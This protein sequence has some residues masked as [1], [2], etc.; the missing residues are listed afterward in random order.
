[1]TEKE[2]IGKI[3]KLRQIR[4]RKDWVSLTKSQILGEEPRF[5]FFPYFKPS[6]VL[7]KIWVGKPA[8]AIFTVVFIFLGT[9][10]YGL[11]KNS[12]PGD[13]L[14]GIR[15]VVHESQ[16]VFISE[17]EKPAFQLKLANE[18]LEDLT[19]ASAKNL[20]PTINEFQ[21]NISAAAKTL[22]KI[23]ATTTDPVM[24]KKIVEETKK[25]EENKQKV[26]SL[27]VVIEGEET[28]EF[29]KALAKIVENL[30]EDLKTRT[31][32]EEKAKTLEEMEKLFEEGKYSEAL[33][34]YLISQ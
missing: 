12:L 6:Q 2:L 8:F 20:A 18:R 4:P 24:I 3:R 31:L 32:T 9:F 29:E 10:G 23:D 28:E 33:E 34:L 11:V 22:S 7:N 17:T 13:L 16:A 19:K 25:L 1:M 21:A 30:I 15:K 27:G 14:Y 5:T 26:E